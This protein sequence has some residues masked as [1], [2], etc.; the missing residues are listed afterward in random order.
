MAEENKKS[1]FRAFAS[2]AKYPDCKELEAKIK[3]AF[4]KKVFRALK[5]RN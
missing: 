2:R 4:M 5:C 3:I 1:T